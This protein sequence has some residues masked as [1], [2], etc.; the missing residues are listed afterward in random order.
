MTP[1]SSVEPP[2]TI[3][4]VARALGVSRGTVRDIIDRGELGTVQVGKRRRVMASE[5]RRYLNGEANK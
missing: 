2:L 1:E 4:E 3:T 5:L